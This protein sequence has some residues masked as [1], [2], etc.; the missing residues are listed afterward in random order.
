LLDERNLDA[1]QH[2]ADLLPQ[3]NEPSLREPLET[4]GKHIAELDFDT[5]RTAIANLIA[6][7]DR[8]G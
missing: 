5:A 7:F 2:F 1:L 4:A 6:Q 8:V 3:V